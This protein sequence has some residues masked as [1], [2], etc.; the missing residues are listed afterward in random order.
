MKRLFSKIETKIDNTT[1]ES[2]NV[3]GKVF[4]VGRQTVTVEDVLAEGE[5]FQQKTNRVTEKCLLHNLGGFAIV[6]LV[7]AGNGTRM[8]L[9]R[10]YV[11][12]EQDLNVAK[13]EIQIAVSFTKLYLT[14]TFGY[15]FNGFRV[16]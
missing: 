9:K 13:R 8:A 11:N 1:R 3:I 12:N 6:Y 2:N 4:N 16:A 15:I 7:K 5:Y 10:M 14:V